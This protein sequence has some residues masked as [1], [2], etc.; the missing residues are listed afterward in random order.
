MV[1]DT[2]AAP[3]RLFG[4]ALLYQ[5]GLP[6]ARFAR[7]SCP[8]TVEALDEVFAADAEVDAAAAGVFAALRVDTEHPAA[9]KVRKLLTAARPIPAELAGTPPLA[10]ATERWN[11]ALRRRDRCLA[12]AAERFVADL[13]ETRA[14]L[15]AVAGDPTFREALA[16]T[17]PGFAPQALD[18]YIRTWSA[19]HRDSDTRYVESKLVAYLQRI[20]TK[21]HVS[22]LLGMVNPAR[23]VPDRTGFRLR[24]TRGGA[25]TE[26]ATFIGYWVVAALARTIA[27]DP[28]V[29]PYLRPVLS[30][31]TDVTERGTVVIGVLDATVRLNDQERRFTAAVDGERRIDEIAQAL[32]ITV[33]A[34]V[35]LADGL[36]QRGVVNLDP[37]VPVTVFQPL[38]A[39]ADQVRALPD[40]CASREYW[41]EMLVRLARLRDD[42]AAGDVAERGA[43]LATAEALF[44]GVT[45]Q[46]A[47]RNAGH[48]YGDRILFYEEC[49]GPVE[50]CVVG[51]DLAQAIE[52]RLR[53]PLDVCA[54]YGTL[55]GRYYRS[56]AL[57]AYRSVAAGNGQPVPFTTVALAMV[58]G[59][60]PDSD[61][62]VRAFEARWRRLV[63]ERTRGRVAELVP[64]DLAA[65]RDSVPGAK[66]AAH[67]AVDLFVSATGPDDL[68]AG[69]AVWVMGEVGEN[70]MPWGSQIY[71]HPDRAAVLDEVADVFAKIGYPQLA[72]IVPERRHKGMLNDG[73]AGVFVL[74]QAPVGRANRTLRLKD[75]FVRGDQERVWLAA[76]DG[77]ELRFFHHHDDKAHLWAF[78]PPRILLPPLAAT[79]FR[80][81]VTVSDVVLL[82]AEW[83]VTATDWLVGGD[84]FA[85]FHRVRR[86]QGEH[87]IPDQVFARLPGELKPY[88]VDLTSVLSVQL[89]SG[90]LRRAGSAVLTEMLP[91][92]DGLWLHDG[93]DRYCTELRTLLTRSSTDA[94]GEGR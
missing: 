57:R 18:R 89:L 40:R 91:G 74:A 30:P 23:V 72:I 54:A 75:L 10:D 53:L 78:A 47:R 32:G 83:D 69:R 44:G 82:R 46:P 67:A 16:T 92:P 21:T 42:F 80:P 65:L 81:R 39:L 68:P 19:A 12:R 86:L 27:R 45:G 11:E 13:A 20:T 62:A 93:R 8:G 52:E 26:R 50:E 85:Q 64:A 66:P 43:A 90:A 37:R 7:L 56:L 6:F 84:D 24:V 35:A 51:G 1:L 38:A 55:L 5:A 2:D 29:R 79:P 87:G 15:R 70:V 33:A 73:F 61:P 31:L 59:P 22:S 4:H 58:A 36:A 71:F 17:N 28:Q 94:A 9:R 49:R 25:P 88:C 60:T 41:L 76:A 63:A 77:T 14:E 3:W 34:G 48:T